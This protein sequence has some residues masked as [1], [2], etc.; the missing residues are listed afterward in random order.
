VRIADVFVL[1]ALP[2]RGRNPRLRRDAPRAAVSVANRSAGLTIHPNYLALGSA[3]AL[4]FALLWYGRSARSTLASLVAVPFCWRRVPPGRGRAPSPRDRGRADVHRGAPS[5]PGLVVVLPIAGM[6][7]IALLM[8][9]N[10]G[11]QVIHQLRLGSGDSSATGSDTQRSIDAQIAREQIRAHRCRLRLLGD[12]RRAQ[13]LP[14]DPGRG[15]IIAGASFLVYLGGLVDITRRALA[16]VQRDMVAAGGG[17]ARVAVNG[18][19]DNQIA[20]KYLYVAPASCWRCHDWRH[21]GSVRVPLR[22]AARTGE[23]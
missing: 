8:F 9:T 12:H 5:A 20:D 19:F 4:P 6:A 21:S 11:K 18:I 13:H 7:L 16:G 15:R 22:P 17:G 3:M 23:A 10:T 1:G 2:A 14:A